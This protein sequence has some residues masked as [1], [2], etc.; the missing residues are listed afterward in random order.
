MK[1]N[2][3][4]L[5]SQAINMSGNG[6]FTN[7]TDLLSLRNVTKMKRT[8]NRDAQLGDKY[9]KHL[10]LKSIRVSLANMFKPTVSV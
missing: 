8:S 2:I 3:R 4:N 1:Q 10:T 6:S 9:L 5:S 7:R